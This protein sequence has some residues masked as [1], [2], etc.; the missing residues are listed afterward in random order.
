[1]RLNADF[2]RP[3]TV[4]FEDY[5]WVASP[6][7]GV[8]RV[9]LDRIGAEKARATSIVRYAPRSV[10]PRHVHPG[11]E[12]ILVLSGVFSEGDCHYPAGYYLRNPPGS[13]HQ[14][15]SHDGATLFV[16]LW[17]MQPGDRASVRLDT[18]DPAAW[19]SS[20]GRA[21]C[22]LFEDAHEQVS[23]QRLAPQEP[24]FKR[25]H[26]GAEVLVVDGQIENPG[27]ILR[28]GSWM[29]LPE[30][31]DPKFASGT[32]GAVLFVKTGHLRG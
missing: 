13:S 9:M 3:V 2:S 19:V 4:A 17:Q 20:E 10:F 6:Q 25:A 23:L 31:F 24:V 18:T 32:D 27:Q 5:Q 28:K 7:A 22:P 11:G 30:G 29:R 26:R 8:A 16:K 1:M 21:I 15:S 14:P 12:E